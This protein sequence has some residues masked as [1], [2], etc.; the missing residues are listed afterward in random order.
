MLDKKKVMS[1]PSNA[2]SLKG[3]NQT[4]NK[5]GSSTVISSTQATSNMS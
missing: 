1:D 5:G 2:G 3:S 4:M